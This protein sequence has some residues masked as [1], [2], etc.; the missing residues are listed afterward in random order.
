MADLLNGALGEGIEGA[1]TFDFI[2]EEFDAVGHIIAEG[3][4]I[5]D[6]ATDGELP[7]FEDEIFA[8]EAVFGEYIDDGIHVEAFAFMNVNPAGVQGFRCYN[9]FEERFRVGND[10]FPG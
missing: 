3:E 5:N 9:F 7:G 10:D 4:D 2:V 6:T 1:D 8:V